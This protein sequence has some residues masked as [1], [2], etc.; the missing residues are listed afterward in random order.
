VPPGLSSSSPQ[1]V[2]Q[3]E[4]GGD[5]E[6]VLHPGQDE[7]RQRGDEDERDQGGRASP[8]GHAAQ[9][10]IGQDDR[11][12]GEEQVQDEGRGLAD[13]GH[14]I[15]QREQ[16]RPGQRRRGGREPVRRHAPHAVPGQAARDGHVD[17]RVVERVHQAA[18]GVDEGGA[19]KKRDRPRQ[20]GEGGQRRSAPR[21]Q[22]PPAA[23]TGAR[24]S[25][26]PSTGAITRSSPM[27]RSN[28]SGRRLCAPVGER[29]SG[30]LCTR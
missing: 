1:A 10:A 17:V 6:G 12:R 24:G 30:S 5:L 2:E 4:D 15:G 20:H 28:C 27:R 18:A 7:R 19:E 16:Q 29:L 8:R 3:P 13:A 9:K 14:E 26:R 25:E 23:G 11:H 21:D 22:R